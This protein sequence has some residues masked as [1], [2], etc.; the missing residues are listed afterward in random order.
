MVQIYRI[1]NKSI[2]QFIVYLFSKISPI[3]SGT[4][5][6]PSLTTGKITA[7]TGTREGGLAWTGIIAMNTAGQEIFYTNNE[8][9]VNFR[10]AAVIDGICAPNSIECTNNAT[11]GGILSC[12][13]FKSSGVDGISLTTSTGFTSLRVF[14]DTGN[15]TIPAN[16]TVSGTLNVGGLS[17]KPWHVAGRVDGATLQ[18]LSNKGEYPFTVSRPASYPL[19]IFL[20][21]WEQEHPDGANYVACC[22]GEGGGWNDLVNG[23]GTGFPTPSGRVMNVA[24]RKLWQGGQ[25]GQSEGL[26]D[27]VFSFFILK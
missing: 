1:K 9:A 19:G 5:T 18:I 4:V 20:I 21:N 26:V 11:F 14:N 8:R 13:S 22:S 3:F 25:A 6:S 10:G 12:S 27:C 23:V 24:F 15:I 17:Y 2:N 16:L 7:S